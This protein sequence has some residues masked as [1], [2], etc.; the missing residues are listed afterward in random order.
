MENVFEVL[1][2][3]VATEDS[4]LLIE[5]LSP[6]A[7]RCSVPGDKGWLVLRTE[8]AYLIHP[9]L[10]IGYRFDFAPPFSLADA[11]FGAVQTEA[12]LAG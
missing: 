6:F 9:L 11:L 10:K 8:D 3:T 7:W 1:T 4:N 12:R 2:K 5:P